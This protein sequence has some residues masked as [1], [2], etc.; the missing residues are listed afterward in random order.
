MEFDDLLFSQWSIAEF[1]PETEFLHGFNFQSTK[2]HDNETFSV[3][4]QGGFSNRFS[5]LMPFQGYN[6][7]YHEEII[8]KRQQEI[9]HLVSQP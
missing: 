9:I 8:K 5:K 6:T 2:I 4:N 7:G 3:S 1:K